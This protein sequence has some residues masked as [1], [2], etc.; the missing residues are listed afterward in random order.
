MRKQIRPPEPQVLQ[1]HAAKWNAEWSRKVRVEMKSSKHF[2]WR[3]R[4]KQSVR[5]LIL[6]ALRSMNQEHESG[7]RIRSIVRFATPIRCWDSLSSRSSTS[8]PKLRSRK[9]RIPGPTCTTLVSTVRTPRAMTGV[10]TCC[11]PTPM[12]TCSTHIS[13]ST[14]R[15]ASCVPTWPPSRNIRFRLA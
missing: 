5:D 11:V 3:Q 15:Q 14:I 2:N 13:T 4:N 8:S 10:R 7:A 1:E 9:M 6:P 12:I